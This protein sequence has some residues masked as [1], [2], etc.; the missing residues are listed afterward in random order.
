MKITNTGKTK[1]GRQYGSYSF[2][3]CTLKD[4]QDLGLQPDD[5]IILSRI[6]GNVKKVPMETGTIRN[7]SLKTGIIVKGDGKRGRKPKNVVA[8]ILA[9]TPA[10]ATPVLV[11]LVEPENHVVVQPINLDQE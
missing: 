8:P 2:G 6:F 9:E 10:G 5:K 4:L 1:Q 7:L 3:V 11:Q